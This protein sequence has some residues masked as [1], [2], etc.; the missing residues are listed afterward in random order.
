MSVQEEL[1][2]D[3]FLI[4]GTTYWLGLTDLAQEGSRLNLSIQRIYDLVNV[5]GTYRWQE[6]HS[7]ADYVNWAPTEPTGRTDQNCIWKTYNPTFP[8][9]HDAGC[10]WSSDGLNPHALC[11][12]AK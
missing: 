6:S 3:T 9:W 5:V 11:E 1:L 7:V 12:T 8:G 2:L 10:S 4:E